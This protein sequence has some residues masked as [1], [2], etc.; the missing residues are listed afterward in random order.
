MMRRSL[1]VTMIRPE[2]PAGMVTL[3]NVVT[4]VSAKAR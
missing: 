4:P 1:G 2:L 3:D